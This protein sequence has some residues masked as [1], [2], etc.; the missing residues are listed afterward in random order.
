VGTN[1]GL[2]RLDG[3]RSLPVEPLASTPIHALATDGALLWIGSELGLWRQS[4]G[5]PQQVS[6]RIDRKQ[7]PISEPVH[8][9]WRQNDKVLWFGRGAMLVR[10]DLQLNLGTLYDSLGAGAGAGEQILAITG[11]AETLWL[12][13]AKN[14]VRYALF[15]GG[16]GDDSETFGAGIPN[17]LETA[18]LRTLALDEAGTVWFATQTGV[19]RYQDWAWSYRVSETSQLVVNDILLDRTGALWLATDNAG[20]RRRGVREQAAFPVPAEASALPG[21]VVYALAEDAAGVI[22][23][24][25]DSGFARFQNGNWETPVAA[26]RLPRPAVTHLLAQGETLWIGTPGGLAQYDAA[27]NRLL[28]EPLLMGQVVAAM[29]FDDQQSVWVATESGGLWQRQRDGAW[30]ERTP[31]GADAAHPVHALAAD[32]TTPGAMLAA[33]P[34]A[35]LLRWSNG[36]WQERYAGVA[37]LRDGVDLIFPDPQLDSLW[38][39]SAGS[40]YRVDEVGWSRYDNEDGMPGGAMRTIVRDKGSGGLWFGGSKGLTY[41]RDE[42]TRP[43]VTIGGLAGAGVAQLGAQWRVDSASSFAV[44]FA[45]GD[46][47]SPPHKVQSY[48][49]V[50]ESGGQSAWQP[51]AP[52]RIEFALGATGL[53]TVEV[54]VRD[55]SF[56]YSAPALIGFEVVTPP[57]TVQLPLVG[58]LEVRI[59]I[60]LLLFGAMAVVGGGYS[61]IEV[62]SRRRQV[63]EEI[64]RGFN[65]YISGEPVRRDEMFFGRHALLERIYTTLHQNSLM[66]HGERRIGKTTMLHQLANVLDTVDDPAYWF[67]PVYVDLEGTTGETFFH[68]LMEDIANVVC[69]LEELTVEQSALL[70]QLLVH[71]TKRTAY[72]DT[73]FNRDLRR[74]IRILEAVV[75]RVQPGKKLRLILLLDEMD[76]F[77]DF[78]PLFQQQ[79]RRIFMRDFGAVLGAVVAGIAIN[80]VWDRDDSPWFNFFNEVPVE[81]FSRE[82]VIELLTEPVRG[83]Y[84]YD[85]DALEFIVAHCDGRPFRAQQ[86]GLEAVNHMLR[87]GRRRIMLADAR[88]AHQRIQSMEQTPVEAPDEPAP[89]AVSGAATERNVT[90]TAPIQ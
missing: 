8:A 36:Q 51:A 33:V 72:T 17:P 60:L 1:T 28:S 11:N 53:Y 2:F 90:F 58:E 26:Y 48:Y 73:E 79:L 50:T 20:V 47:Q 21:T 66:L 78:D 32:P 23:A 35:G 27:A 29:A 75:E 62:L 56:N 83:Y 37:L 77:N 46:L 69:G 86:F 49:R 89:G 4:E 68:M 14:A 45:G 85:P 18:T 61:A 76:T 13:G 67:L 81:P 15:A 55:Q 84:T 22:W 24:G 40:L 54:V 30:A 71:Q 64:K 87:A 25:T 3:E 9:I 63:Q 39:G 43:Y 34:G 44:T 16:L 57:N 42:T 31:L 70:D 80:K 7:Q 52:G 59:V 12:T 74:L 65:P 88:F 38:V 41:F 5:R 82:Q 6:L 10:Y 19:Y